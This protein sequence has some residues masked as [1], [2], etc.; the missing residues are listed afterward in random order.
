MSDVI[1]IWSP[2]QGEKC[3][4]NTG[5]SI[6][7][8]SLS[9]NKHQEG[10][11]D[12]NPQLEDLC[13]AL[14]W[15]IT[16]VGELSCIWILALFLQHKKNLCSIDSFSLT[17]HLPYT[18]NTLVLE[19]VLPDWIWLQI[20]S[21]LCQQCPVLVYKERLFQAALPLKPDVKPQSSCPALNRTTLRPT[22][23]SIAIYSQIVDPKLISFNFS[24]LSSQTRWLCAVIKIMQ[25]E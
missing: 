9:L 23:K 2:W 3:S 12:D 1:A 21:W 7:Y 15:L 13:H 24:P 17:L 5:A 19:A 6:N 11:N 20:Q 14:C 8:F 10:I 22:Q 16:V 4:I 25:M 18:N